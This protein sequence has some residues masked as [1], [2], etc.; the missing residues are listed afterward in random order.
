[1]TEP[2]KS[3]IIPIN[4]NIYPQIIVDNQEYRQPDRPVQMLGLTI[5]KT[6]FTSAHV[7]AQVKKAKTALSSIK[8]YYS[9]PTNKKLQLVK[10][11]VLSHLFYPPIPLHVAS[12]T[13]LNYNKSKIKHSNGYTI[14]NGMILYAI[15]KYTKTITLDQ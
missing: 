7:V 1:M 10:S 5:T 13:N 8:K 6:S 12:D 3:W 14:S 4:Q 2:A 11:L 15:K 9:L